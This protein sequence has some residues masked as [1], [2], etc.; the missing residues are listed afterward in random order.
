MMNKPRIAV[1]VA[2]YNTEKYIS[3]CLDSI[4]AQDYEQ[5]TAYII[6]DGSTDD[7]SNICKKY[8]ESDSRFVLLNKENGGCSQARRFGI[9]CVENCE[10][11]TFLDSDDKYINVHLFSQVIAKISEHGCVCFN[12]QVGDGRPFS[13]CDRE[14][15]FSGEKD[16]IK[17]IYCRRI[18][19]GNSQYAVYPVDVVKKNFK[20]LECANDDYINKIAM[21][22]NCDTVVYLPLIAYMYRINQSGLTHSLPKESDIAYY[23]H[24]KEHTSQ[25]IKRFPE[26]AEEADYFKNWILLWTATVISKHKESSNLSYYSFVL[27]EIDNE[28]YSY[29]HNKYFSLRNR[30]TFWLIRLRV[31]RFLY[32]LYHMV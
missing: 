10:Y 3:E 24:A 17:N 5:W 2:A 19:D 28:A 21:V 20:T 9:D 4:L 15:V 1:I 26:I 25:N 8:E 18:I 31:F 22:S 11:L 7:T 23:L 13:T 12:Y 29:M 27:H 14:Y 6:N 32:N 30:L 16:I